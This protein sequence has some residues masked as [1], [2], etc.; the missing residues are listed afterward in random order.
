[1]NELDPSLYQWF[2]IPG[3][4]F[5]EININTREVRSNKHYKN[6][7]HHI[8]KGS[9]TRGGSTVIVD[10]YGIPRRVLV[11]YLYDLTFNSGHKLQFRAD[12]WQPTG[13][14]LKF[15]RNQSVGMDYSKFVQQKQQ[16]IK[17]ITFN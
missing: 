3:F 6:D 7:S 8:M 16:L 10:D 12:V 1:M 4:S 2:I 11:D 17:P 9:K 14:M 13:G 5:Y 15:N